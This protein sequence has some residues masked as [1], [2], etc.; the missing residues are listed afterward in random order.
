MTLVSPD[1]ATC[2]ECVAELFDARRPPLPLP[3]HQLHEL[4]A[5]LHDH[6]RR[7]LRP[8]DDH[9]ARLPDVPRVRRRVRRPGRPALPRAAG[10][11]LHLRAAAL[12]E[13]PPGRDADP[14]LRQTRSSH[15]TARRPDAELA[16][17][18]P[19]PRRRDRRDR[20]GSDDESLDR[21]RSRATTA[22]RRAHPRDQGARRLPPRVRRDERGGGRARCASASTAGASRSRSWCATSR[23]RAPTARSADAEE[24]ELLD[25]RRP[26]DRAAAQARPARSSAAGGRARRRSRPASPTASPRSA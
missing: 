12:P 20:I 14:L 1:I 13:C 5:A 21:T 25:G 6:R 23:P 17:P 15:R 24:A 3:V 18:A 8:A 26:P 2:P 4:R 22:A 19:G 7:A 11:L 16:A 9:D 10:R